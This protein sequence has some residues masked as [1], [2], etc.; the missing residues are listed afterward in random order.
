[1]GAL[2]TVITEVNKTIANGYVT[3]PVAYENA[4]FDNASVKEYISVLVEPSI[5][6]QMT[7][8]NVNGTYRL[9]GRVKLEIKTQSESGTLTNANIASELT[10]LFLSKNIN[11]IQFRIPSYTPFGIEAGYFQGVVYIGFYYD[12]AP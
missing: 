1:M 6:D 11:G 5:T 9:F 4:P 3:T 10:N 8:N 7:I 12:S 2:S